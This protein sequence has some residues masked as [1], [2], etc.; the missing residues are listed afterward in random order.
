MIS[1]LFFKKTRKPLFICKHYA[2]V[3]V[4]IF[5]GKDQRGFTLPFEYKSLLETGMQGTVKEPWAFSVHVFIRFRLLKTTNIQIQPGAHPVVSVKRP[6]SK[7]PKTDGKSI[8]KARTWFLRLHKDTQKR[9]PSTERSPKPPS[10]LPHGSCHPSSPFSPYFMSLTCLFP[11][12][13]STTLQ[14]VQFQPLPT[15]QIPLHAVPSYE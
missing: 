4:C 15:S 14:R 7:K 5:T 2:Q 1:H 9:V 3:S 13:S 10:L 11:F 12:S 8:S 6:R